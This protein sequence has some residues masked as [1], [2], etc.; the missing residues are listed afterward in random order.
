WMSALQPLASLAQALPGAGALMERLTGFDRRRPLPR[1]QRA[2]TSSAPAVHGQGA[3]VVL[4][5][6]TFNNWIE[7]GNL[8]ATHKVLAT[9]GHEIVVPLGSDR[10]LC[11]GRTYLTAGM[12]DEARDEARRTLEALAPHIDA[13]T[14]IL[15]L[16]PSCLF[17]FRDEYLAM[18]PGDDRVRRLAQLARLADEYLADAIASGRAK[19]PWR[20]GEARKIR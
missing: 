3:R 13:G 19:L 11:C 16:E 18:F 2:W 12:I 9:A 6:D 10:P 4:F 14:P 8:V 17:T 20:G 5:A 15:G 1:L 7:P